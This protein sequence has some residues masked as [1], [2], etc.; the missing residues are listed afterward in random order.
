MTIIDR[1]R[2]RARVVDENTSNARYFIVIESKHSSSSGDVRFTH[3]ANADR[4][5]NAINKA[6]RDEGRLLGNEWDDEDDD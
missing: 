2:Q 3:K 5:A 1:T 6:Y 4:I